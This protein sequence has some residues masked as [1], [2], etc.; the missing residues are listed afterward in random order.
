MPV[1]RKWQTLMRVARDRGLRGACSLIALKIRRVCHMTLTGRVRLGWCF[2]RCDPH[3]RELLLD[4]IYEWKERYAAKHFIRRDL[5][6]VD[7]GASLGV[8]SCLLN[9]RL[10]YPDRHV[11]VEANPDVFEMLQKNRDH[12]GCKFEALHRAIGPNGTVNIHYGNGA[13]TGGAFAPAAFSAQV[14]TIT[15]SEIAATK[16][17]NQFSLICDIEGAEIE[18]I[19]SEI[20]KLKSSVAVIVIE[21][22]PRISGPEPVERAQWLLQEGGFTQVW[23]TDDVFAY[24]NTRPEFNHWSYSRR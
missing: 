12:N 1:A 18:L 7:L 9:R 16:K 6:V 24:R 10:V 15:L 17:L 22:H 20:E 13:I 11:A 5:P 3:G 19:D 8:V 4:G 2:F 14:P 23:H 21:F